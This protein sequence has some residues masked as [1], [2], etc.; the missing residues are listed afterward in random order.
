MENGGKGRDMGD[1]K[2]V[3]AHLVGGCQKECGWV[4]KRVWLSKWGQLG[5]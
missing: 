2:R 5:C 4:F 1:G 3:W